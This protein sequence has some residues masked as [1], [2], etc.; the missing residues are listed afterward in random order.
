MGIL[1]RLERALE[2]LIEG[3]LMGRFVG[4]VHPLEMARRLTREM[5]AARRISTRSVFVPNDFRVRLGEADAGSLAAIREAVQAE[6][7]EFLQQQAAERNFSMIG[8]VVVQIVEDPKVDAGLMQIDAAFTP[9]PA[10]PMATQELM[11]VVPSPPGPSPRRRPHPVPPGTRAMLRGEDGFARG[12]VYYLHLDSLVMGRKEDC[13]LHLLDPQV[14]N[15]H[16]T[17]EWTGATYRL[18][19]AGSRNGTRVNG[20]PLEEARDLAPGDVI[21]VGTS[22]L[23]YEPASGI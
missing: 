4:R 12:H 5:Q 15:R 14:S 9:G 11:R 19:D 2:N 13:H 6:L 23:R 20:A 10:Q 18:V 8:P 16:A 3:H 1:D 21:G 22:I 7:T 17:L